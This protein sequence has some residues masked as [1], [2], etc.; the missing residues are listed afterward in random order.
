M[1]DRLVQHYEAKYGA[2]RAS[3]SDQTVTIGRNP[4]GRFEGAVA[5]LATRLDGKDVLEL[6]AGSGAVAACLAE[7]TAVSTWTLSEQSVSRLEGMRRRLGSNPQFRF[8]TV[9]AS[10]PSATS[11]EQFDVVVHMA[12]IEHLIDPLGAMTDTR[13]LLRPGGFVYIETPNI[14]KWTR[15]LK[16]LAGRFPSTA[17]RREGLVTYEGQPVDLYDEGHLHYFSYRSLERMLVDRCGFSRVE[18]VPYAVDRRPGS[19][20]LARQWP[21]LFAEISV[22]AHA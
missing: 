9:D 5:V 1:S 6:G 17:S 8:A 21:T 13:S 16:L 11:G 10:A 20:W 18:R 19:G 12:L 22:L 2:E 15:R 7:A 4:V 3:D 14:A